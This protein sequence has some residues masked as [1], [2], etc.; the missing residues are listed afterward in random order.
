MKRLFL[1]FM[2][3][4]VIISL[5]WLSPT[6]AQVIFVVPD[7]LTNVAG[8]GAGGVFPCFP[9]PSLRAQG[10]F[11]G[12]QIG[13]GTI[14]GSANRSIP[15]GA[16]YA[17]VVL[18][19][20][21][22]RL[23]T[24]SAQPGALSTTFADNVGPD[25]TTVFQGNLALSSPNCTTSPCPFNAGQVLFQTEF[26]FDPANGNL[27]FDFEIP[28]C[29]PG[30]TD[31]D[32]TDQFPNIMSGV[33]G[34]PFNSP[35]GVTV[36]FILVTQFTIL[37]GPGTEACGEAQ[38]ACIDAIQG[39]DFKNHGQKVKA[40][41][42]ASNSPDINDECHSCIVN[43]VARGIPIEE[44]EN[45]G[46]DVPPVCTEGTDPFSGDPWVVCE[47]DENEAWL[48]HNV[49]GGGT[50]A[51]ETICQ[52]LGYDGLGQNGGNCGDVCGYCQAE[53][54]SCENAG[55]KVFDGSNSCVT[56]ELCMTVTWT[57]VNN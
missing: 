20:I 4:F 35:T 42:K 36:D 56:P 23:S 18:P 39:V 2:V 14:I 21:T 33:A 27:L 10:V 50:Y 15:F 43:Q 49:A 5:L 44:L 24:T 34:V 8:N 22:V 40:C 29:M 26:D 25:V 41:A 46:T 57:C 3:L 32:T 16:G 38:Q 45:C 17:P 28:Q 1:T 11:L 48:S 47:A 6:R 19:N 51:S 12:S 13:P 30:L 55:N 52:G 54:T 7:A 53:Q 9:F 37:A 31:G